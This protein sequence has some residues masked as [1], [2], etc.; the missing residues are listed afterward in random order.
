MAFNSFWALYEITR[1]SELSTC[2]SSFV[3]FRGGGCLFVCFWF[4]VVFFT[5]VNVFIVAPYFFRPGRSKNCIVTSLAV[6]SSTYHTS[7]ST[8]IWGKSVQIGL[9][10][11]SALNYEAITSVLRT[12]FW[13]NSPSYST[14][15]PT[16]MVMF[17][18]AFSCLKVYILL[19]I[20][21]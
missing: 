13:S 6:V 5:V 3:H 18:G 7:Q 10:K 4:F 2:M 21:Y 8:V 11:H 1:N 16:Y 15:L 17:C 19:I 9:G 14:S 20:V 12:K